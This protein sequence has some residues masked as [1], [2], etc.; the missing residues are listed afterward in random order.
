MEI[1]I[2]YSAVIAVYLVLMAFGFGYDRAVAWWEK[3]K[4]LEGFVSLAVALGVL[5]TLGGVWVLSWQAALLAL[6]A[7]VAS[8][9]P[10]IIGSIRRYVIARREAQDYERQTAGM[11]KPG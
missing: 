5:I 4:Y 11:G 1:K 3:Q 7:F 6:G 9:A 2:D 8:G 10:M